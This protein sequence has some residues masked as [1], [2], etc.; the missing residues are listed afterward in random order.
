MDSAIKAEQKSFVQKMG[1]RPQDVIMPGVNIAA[2]AA[3]SPSA[4]M[5]ISNGAIAFTY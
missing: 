4:G 1:Q 2:D 3:M 5:K